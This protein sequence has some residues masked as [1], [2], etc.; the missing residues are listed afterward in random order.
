MESDIFILQK[1]IDWSTLIYG[2]NIPVLLQN[3]G[4]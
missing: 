2:F 3:I 1:Q 4:K